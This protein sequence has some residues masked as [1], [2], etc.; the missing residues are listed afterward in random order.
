M[1]KY[2]FRL[3]ITGL[4]SRSQRAIASLNT[5]CGENLGEQFQ[6]EIVDVLQEPEKAERD[7]ILATPTLVKQLPPPV[8]RVIGDLS[9]RQKVLAVLN[10]I[11]PDEDAGEEKEGP[12]WEDT[13]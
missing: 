2:Y 5:L 8:R 7:K 3:F 12:D 9:D 10:L 4:T 13:I 6:L 11:P 1:D